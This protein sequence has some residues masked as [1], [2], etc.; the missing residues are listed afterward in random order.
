M[1]LYILMKVFIL[2]TIRPK[3]GLVVYDIKLWG[4]RGFVIHSLVCHSGKH[5]KLNHMDIALS[6]VT[7]ECNG[8]HDGW[9]MST[10]GPVWARA[11]KGVV[12]SRNR[13]RVRNRMDYLLY[14][15]RVPTDKP[16]GPRLLWRGLQ[17]DNGR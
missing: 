8:Q 17:F 2:A 10:P 6:L 9:E 3:G 5:Y 16:A 11:V 12:N 7:T 1:S 15:V 13:N 4:G 14:S